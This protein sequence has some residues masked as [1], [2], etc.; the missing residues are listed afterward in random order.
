MG[1]NDYISLPHETKAVNK[2]SPLLLLNSN[3]SILKLIW[4]LDIIYLY[5]VDSIF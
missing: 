5:I 2:W 1:E 4:I 3:H